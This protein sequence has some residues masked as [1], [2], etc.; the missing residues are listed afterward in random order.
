[1]SAHD[2]L[3]GNVLGGP[4]ADFFRPDITTATIDCAYCGH[5]AALAEFD[6]Y[7][8]APALVVRCPG[9]ER[10]VLRVASDRFGLR[11]EMSGVRLMSIPALDRHERS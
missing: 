8:D 3:D 6:V 10:A 5:A 9:C 1:M 11:L 2:R 7:P 4:L